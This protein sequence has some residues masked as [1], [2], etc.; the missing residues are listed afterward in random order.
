MEF[1]LFTCHKLGTV[2]VLLEEYSEPKLN[3]RFSEESGF[4][5]GRFWEVPLH[6]GIFV[7]RW[8]LY[9]MFIDHPVL[10]QKITTGID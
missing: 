1:F 4:Q 8:V 6:Y 9:F 2:V 7:Y 3:V 10:H 5:R